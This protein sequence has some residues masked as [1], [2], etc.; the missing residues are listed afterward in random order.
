MQCED[1]HIGLLSV[2]R[3]DALIAIKNGAQ[4]E[5]KLMTINDH[6]ISSGNI[7]LIE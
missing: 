1:T 7:V 4:P 6:T 3:R 2:L 5:V